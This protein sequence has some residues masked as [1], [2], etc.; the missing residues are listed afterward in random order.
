MDGYNTSSIVLCFTMYELAVNPEWQHRV[1]NEIKSMVENYTELTYD[2]L[3]ELNNMNM[4]ISETMRLNPVIGTMTRICT[5]TTSLVDEEGNTFRVEEGTPV[6][7]SVY[8]LH[9]DPQYYPSPE[10]FKPERFL[11]PSQD[12]DQRYA[13]LPF[14]EGPRIC[15]GM[16][17]GQMVVKACLAAILLN[18]EI[19]PTKP[20]QK[21]EPDTSSSFLNIAKGGVWLKFK[22]LQK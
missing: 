15:P 20:N 8:A 16:K 17:F 19:L 11:T 4:V 13:Y 9:M 22:P 3:L 21:I 6:A 2:I 7:I 1:R 18:F 5:K 12:A 14:G 10:E